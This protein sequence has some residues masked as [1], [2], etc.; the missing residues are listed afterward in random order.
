[1]VAAV[2]GGAS[3][4]GAAVLAFEVVPA[5]F[6]CVVVRDREG[7]FGLA[8]ADFG[9]D[10]ADVGVA[11]AADFA[12]GFATGAAFAFA[13]KPTFGFAFG[14]TFGFAPVAA[15]GAGVAALVLDAAGFLTTGFDRVA[16]RTAGPSPVTG[17]APGR[18]PAA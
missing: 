6:G 16:R 5:A 2:A 13:A 18:S 17:S 4:A 9:L 7:A 14:A 10:A 1:M 15:F 8:A 3:V 12:F 11:A